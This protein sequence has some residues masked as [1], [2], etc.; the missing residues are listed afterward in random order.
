M[1][2]CIIPFN[3]FPENLVTTVLIIRDDERNV[4][5]CCDAC[6]SGWELHHK[7][8]VMGTLICVVTAHQNLPI[9]INREYSIHSRQSWR[10]DARRNAVTVSDSS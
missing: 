7:L 5:G 4:A 8:D 10:Y 6:G 9:P 3:F 1:R 2:R